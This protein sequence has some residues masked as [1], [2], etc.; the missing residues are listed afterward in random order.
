LNYGNIIMV[1]LMSQDSNILVQ[2]DNILAQKFDE[3]LVRNKQEGRSKTSTSKV[4]IDSG[5][6][7]KLIDAL[8][9]IVSKVSE[10]NASPDD[11]EKARKINEELGGEFSELV[12]A[13]ESAVAQQES[14]KSQN[15][16]SYVDPEVSAARKY[17]TTGEVGKSE[18]T[19]R[20]IEAGESTTTEEKVQVWENLS[21]SEDRKKR[22]VHLEELEKKKKDIFK[23]AIL[24]GRT[25]LNEDEKRRV[26]ENDK[27]RL[28][29]LKR[30]H[31][32]KALTSA[33]GPYNKNTAQKIVEDNK[34]LFEKCIKEVSDDFKKVINIVE[35]E[36]QDLKEHLIAN[37]TKNNLNA[38]QDNVKVVDEKMNAIKKEIK[39][40]Q[41]AIV[42][43]VTEKNVLN[44]EENT[45]KKSSLI[46]L[47]N[48][49]E[50]ERI[51][52]ERKRS[53]ML[54]TLKAKK[55]LE[56]KTSTTNSNNS[57]ISPPNGTPP[58]PKANSNPDVH[59][60]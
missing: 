12:A 48:D 29:F 24:E 6:R 26:Q 44:S 45:A 41:V 16:A 40:E 49:K 20:K 2:N 57:Q 34:S 5:K 52:N 25:E 35:R 43:T 7:Q 17:L 50:A 1:S 11:A 3:A 27:T 54:E 38:K 28:A 19:L 4:N 14:L 15:Q 37:N 51:K 30:H 23:T 9:K 33:F 53:I 39:Q 47:E 22:D 31:H 13:V 21:S 59:S 46:N 8:K 55:G 60:R 10:R 18:A 58:M 36:T 56:S 32:D 42:A